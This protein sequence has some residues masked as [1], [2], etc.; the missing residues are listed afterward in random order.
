MIAV[1]FD[2][3]DEHAG[4]RPVIFPCAGVIKHITY[5]QDFEIPVHDYG[6]ARPC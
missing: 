6:S 4:E 5:N 2:P 3:V 1:G